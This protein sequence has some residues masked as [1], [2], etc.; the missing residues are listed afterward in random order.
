MKKEKIKHRCLILLIWMIVVFGISIFLNHASFDP[1]F[2]VLDAVTGA[3][4]KSNKKNNKEKEDISWNYQKEDLCLSKQQ[5]IEEAKIKIK[6]K[7]YYL[8]ENDLEHKKQL[9]LLSNKENSSYQKA[10][11]EIKSYFVKQGY[12]VKVKENTETMM[13]SMIHAGK[14]DLFLMREEEKQ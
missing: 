7:T 5:N 4:K 14:F 10:I 6:D 8:L 9:R 12:Q 13:V 2:S 1:N 11:N 3:T